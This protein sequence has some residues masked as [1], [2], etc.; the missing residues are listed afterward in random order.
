MTYP[1]LLPDGRTLFFA[2][3]VGDHGGTLVALR[4]DRKRVLIEDPLQRIASPA[5]SPSG[6][7]VFQL[8]FPDSKGVWAVAFDPN[9]LSLG[10]EPFLID[11]GGSYPAVAADGTLVY[12]SATVH[13]NVPGRFVWVDRQGRVEPVGDFRR[14]LGTPA[15]SP[16]GHRIAFD[17]VDQDNRDVW[18]RDL[19][20]DRVTRLTFDRA[21]DRFPVWSRDGR[22]IAFQSFRSG[23]GDIYGM[24]VDGSADETLLVNGP[25]NETPNSWTPD[26]HGLVYTYFSEDTAQDLMLA[27]IRTDPHASPAGE[28]RPV[29]RTRRNEGWGHLSP[30]GRYIVYD[31]S[32]SGRFE[33]YVSRIAIADRRW[34]VSSDG[35]AWPRWSPRGDEIFF[36]GG[37]SASGYGPI[38]RVAVR[39]GDDFETD[40]A[41]RLFDS[42]ARVN[43]AWFSVAG[44]ARRFLAVEKQLGEGPT[45][46]LTLVQN[47][48]REF[49]DVTKLRAD[50]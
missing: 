37:G 17:A 30:D 4:D 18:V 44:D 23:A 3:N 36:I 24:P 12:R 7:L 26:G 5:Y 38:M 20:R 13:E 14:G 42:P 41:E 46:T 8:G 27:P 35:G 1:L 29:L 40:P 16:D 33:I 2:A 9:S 15:L 49:E 32:E 45:V 10:G 48:F 28:P 25:R 21:A 43:F 6:H 47:W 31:S 50:Q 39:P 34:Q 19:E 11:E 22:F